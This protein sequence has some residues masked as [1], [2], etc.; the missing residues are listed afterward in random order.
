MEPLLSEAQLMLRCKTIE[1]LT[2]SQLASTIQHHIPSH[3]LQ[4]KGWLGLAIE[5]ALGANAGNSAIPDFMELGVELK[6]LPINALGL[7]AESTFVTSIHLRKL[8]QQTWETSTCFQKLKRVLWIL[9]EDDVKLRFEHR[10]IGMAIMWSPNKEQTEILK[11]DW[12]ELSLMLSSGRL[13]E[14]H[15][16]MGTYLQVRPKAQNSRSL[17]YGFDEQGEKISTTPRGFYLRTC[18]TRQIIKEL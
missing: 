2:Y 12:S 6:T 10:R 1:G 15:A 5:T 16:G 14:V 8:H 7:P 17:C 9:I 11:N 3:P 4:R 18:L 13:T